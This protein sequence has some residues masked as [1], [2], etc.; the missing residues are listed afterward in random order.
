MVIAHSKLTSQG[1]ISVPA[2][3]RGRLGIGP[4]SVLEWLDEG[5]RVVVRRVGRHSSEDIHQALFGTRPRRRTLLQLKAGVKS[6]IRRR[7]TRR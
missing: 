1:K 7:R 4:G 2:P 3:V 5:E 6:Y